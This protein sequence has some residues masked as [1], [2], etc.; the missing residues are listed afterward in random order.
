MVLK[1]EYKRCAVSLNYLL[2]FLISQV[3][4][5]I[6]LCK[7]YQSFFTYISKYKHIFSFPP[8]TQKVVAQ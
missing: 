2:S 8:F 6:V 3:D 4:T 5:V 7:S 1:S